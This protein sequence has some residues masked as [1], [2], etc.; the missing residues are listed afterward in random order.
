MTKS[1][2]LYFYLRK[3]SL[4]SFVSDHKQFSAYLQRTFEIFFKKQA[5]KLNIKK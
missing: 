4:K 1:T 3:K 2:P 5:E